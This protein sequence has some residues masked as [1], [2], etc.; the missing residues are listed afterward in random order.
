MTL[1]E[2]IE[3]NKGYLALALTWTDNNPMK[4]QVVAS[5]RGAIAHAERQLAWLQ[6]RAKCEA[7]AKAEAARIAALP[8]YRRLFA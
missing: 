7:E 1:Q 6:H 8:W 3:V 5:S 4:A 2:E